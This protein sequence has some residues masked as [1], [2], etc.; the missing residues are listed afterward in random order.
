MQEQSADTSARSVWVMGM[1][2]GTTG[3]MVLVLLVYSTLT[4]RPP[5]G[6]APSRA[7]TVAASAET[8]ATAPAPSLAASTARSSPAA[9]P[10]AQF[11][12]PP[13]E[14]H[15]A[16]A[17]PYNPDP[18]VD[19]VFTMDDRRT[20]EVAPGTYYEGW[21]YNGTVPGPVIRVRQGATVN[22]TLV[23]EGRLLHSLDFHSARTQIG[24]YRNVASGESF[25]WSF[26]ARVPGV[27]MY[28][29]GTAPALQHIG[30]GM[31]GVMIVDPD[32]PLPA[33]DREY[34]LLQSEFYYGQAQPNGVVTGDF[35]KMQRFDADVVA[36]NGHQTQ[37][38]DHPLVA[39]PGELVRL[40]VVDAGPTFNSAF[41]VVGE[42]FERVYAGGNPAPEN[43]DSGIQTALVPV[44][45]GAMFDVRPQEAGDYLFVSHAFAHANKG[46]V[47]VLRVGQSPPSPGQNI[48]H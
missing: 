45:G 28:H 35:T 13:H 37:Y 36:F 11:S 3:L 12:A 25:T 2:V 24:N 6:A 7:G 26:V 8:S 21:T 23:N 20:I 31:Y 15:S 14:P 22:V 5:V 29:C 30:N 48:D 32:P 46:A 33:A 41:H 47:G 17:P 9:P 44:G 39:E 43:V 18:V 34:V 16:V 1:L 40:Y 4:T 19:L 10:V 38:R 27:F 42:I